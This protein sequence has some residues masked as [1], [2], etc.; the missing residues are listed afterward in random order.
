M[1]TPTYVNATNFLK[2][3]KEDEAAIQIGSYKQSFEDP[4]IY[5]ED[6]AGSRTGFVHNFD[7]SSSCTITGE[8]N[9]SSLASTMG[10]AFGIA[11]TV[12][13]NISGFGVTTGSF[14]LEDIEFTQDRG[15]LSECT[16][17]LLKITGLV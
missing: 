9:V 7:P 2:G 8:T 17:N 11:E 10:V 13:N 1:P 6:K 3:V 12:A 16:A 15:A 4:K 14:F 5:I